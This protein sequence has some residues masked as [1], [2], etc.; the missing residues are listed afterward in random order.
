MPRFVFPIFVALAA[1]MVL[2]LFVE[3]NETLNA[4]DAAKPA[5]HVSYALGL[6]VGA[7]LGQQGLKAEDIKSAD[8][9]SGIVDGIALKGADLKLTEAEIQA[10]LETL[11]KRLVERTQSAAKENLAKSQAFLDANKAK[12]GVQTLPS[13]L[14]Y[15]ELKKGTGAQPK[16]NSRVT[17]HYEGKL[18]DGK[19]FDSSIERKEPA[20]FGVTQVIPGWTEALQRMRVGD[21]WK[22]VIPPDLAYGEQGRPGIPPNA[23]LVFE[24]ELL[25]VE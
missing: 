9:I 6:N 10:A 15:Q 5:D 23:A 21:K 16:Q 12:D 20:T 1:L 2:P 13:G 19:I 7:S 11:E 8:F 3:S 18:I 22:L 17:V 25:K 4:Q 24:V 14:Q